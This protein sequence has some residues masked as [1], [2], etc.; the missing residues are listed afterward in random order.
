[1]CEQ[2]GLVLKVIDGNDVLVYRIINIGNVHRIFF[3]GNYNVFKITNCI[4]CHVAE[5][6]IV[7][8][9][10]V[11]VGNCK[12]L[13]K[14]MDDL[15]NISFWGDFGNFFCTVGKFLSNG[16]ILH[17]YRCNGVAADVRK[18]I[19]VGVVIATFQKDTVREFVPNF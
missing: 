16:F 15:G 19:I 11:I 4:V 3:F 2:I 9:L 5:Q 6:S 10:E 13:A 12:L 7:D 18:T 14:F 8:K 1:M 17:L